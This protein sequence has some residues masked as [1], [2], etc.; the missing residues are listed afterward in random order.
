M[1]NPFTDILMKI[2]ILILIKMLVNGFFYWT[3]VHK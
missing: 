2:N 3:D 1:E